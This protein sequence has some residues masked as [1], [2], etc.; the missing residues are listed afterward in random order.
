VD[1][2][3]IADG[4]WRWTTRHPDWSPGEEWGPDVGSVYWETED[5][6]VLVD[7]LVPTDEE[8]RARFLDALDRDVQRLGRPV[9]VLLTC[10][11][12]GRSA[13]EL[14]ARYGGRVHQPFED[15]ARPAGV[16]AIGSPAA[17]EVV[18]WLSGARA[19]V[20]GDTLLGSEAGVMFCPAAWLEGRGGLAGLTRD[21]TPLLELPVEHV[22]TTHGPPVLG[23][24]RPAL[25]AA[26]A[27]AQRPA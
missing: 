24:G 15:A 3:R 7:P 13:D 14:A 11:W 19:A 5:S 16:E 12:H 23:G 22:L 17:Q 9:V 26:F 20:P 1:V 21:L 4:L 25:E 10:E 8:D 27:A 18:Y 2:A 6:V